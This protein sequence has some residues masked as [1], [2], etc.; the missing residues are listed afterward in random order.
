[1]QTDQGADH[2]AR[3]RA[4]RRL[5][6]RRTAATTRTPTGGACGHCDSC[7]LRLQGLRR[8]RRRRP[9]RVRARRAGDGMSY[10][11][12]EIF[13][14]LQGE[15]AQRR[16]AGGVL[17][18]RRLQPVDGREEDRATRRLPVLRHRLRRAPTAPAAASSRRA[19]TLAARGRA[20]L[21]GGGERRAARYVVC[22]G[23]EPLLQ[24]D[25]RA[26]RRAARRGLRDRG[27]DQRHA[28]CRRRDR[29]GLRQPEG[30]RATLVLDRGDELK[31]VYPQA[32]A[33]PERF[34]EASTSTTSSCSRWTAPTS[35]ANTA[36]R[37]RLLPRA[38]AVAAEP[39][40]PQG[41][42]ASR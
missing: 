11:V 42:S 15:G 6:A 5:L 22:T 25:A 27:R 29:L 9:D 13:Y 21:A 10:A 37:G 40:D 19:T 7:L 18:L 12:K 14:T 24:L 28:A 41:T 32:G 23:G 31:L 16:P 4:R 35:S 26:D 1:M 33:E 2:P 30:R 38:P 8:G 39:P 17:P 20:T 36:A 34:A 3:A